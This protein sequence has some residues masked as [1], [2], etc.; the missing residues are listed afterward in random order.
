MRSAEYPRRVA[1]ISMHTSP[2]ETPGVGDAGGLNV[3]VAEV[4]RRLGARGVEIDVFTRR[5][6]PNTPDEVSPHENVRVI[7]LAAGPA[8]AM[9]KEDLPP[10]VNEFAARLD[11]RTEDYDLIHSHYWLSGLAGLGLAA[12]REIPLV[13]TMHTMARVKNASRADDHLVEPDVR[14]EGEAAIVRAAEVLT[15]NTPDEALELQEHYGAREEQLAIVPPGVDLDRFHP[16]NRSRTRE[17]LGIDQD[18]QVIVFVGRIQPLKAPDV[19][20][21]AVGELVRRDP[22]RR[23]RLRL[24]IIGSPSGP[25][26]SWA[27][28]LPGLVGSLGLDGIVE[29]RPHS[30][31]DQLFRWYCASDVV[32]VPSYNESFG[33]VALEAQACGRPVVATDVGGLRHA[34]DDESTG[35]LVHGHDP[36]RWADAL[37][38]ILDDPELAVELGRNA[39]T[40]AARFSWDNSAKAT[41]DAYHSA[42]LAVS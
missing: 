36:E 23:H 35:L 6:D 42:R 1:M 15:A 22:E 24:M 25:E 28:T 20:I 27:D 16:C 9:S 37:S 26:S 41:L 19:L 29:F 2:L 4:A 39:A 17:Q 31:R 3:Y 13:H 32:G 8:K 21:Q 14:E 10:L 38:R 11:A 34:V 30:P 18:H 5:T 40:H 33:L 7:Q 12:R